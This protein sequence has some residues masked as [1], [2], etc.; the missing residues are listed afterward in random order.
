[1]PAPS[2]DK[3]TPTPA[4]SIGGESDLARMEQESK[5]ALERGDAAAAAQ[6]FSKLL[7]S[8]LK[9]QGQEDRAEL[10]RWSARLQEAQAQHRWNPRAQW[11]A[12]EVEVHKGD[13]LIAIRK[14]VLASHPNL[15][16][17]TGLIAHANRLR[18]QDSLR[19]GAKLRVP[20]D[21]ASAWV[22]VSAR[23]VLFL[24]GDEVAA[25]WEVGV[26]R[27]AG[28]TRPGTY[29]IGDKRSEPMWFAPGREPVPF[30]DPENPLG[31]RWLAWHLDG[32]PTSLG[33]HGTNDD[34][35]IGGA[36]SEG[37][38]RMRNPDVEL[39]YEILPKDATVRVQP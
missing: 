3:P 13:N 25:A 12:I 36:V 15:L 28:S 23:W 22:D 4:V 8:G 31:T 34:R 11:P 19:V 6:G 9:E 26:G 1:M 21:R 37:C 33:F 18:D 5:A 38:I 24:L 16:L 35:S 20:I 17:S 2:Q 32:A 7:M 10:A 30:G 14:R 39:L 29:T 27:E